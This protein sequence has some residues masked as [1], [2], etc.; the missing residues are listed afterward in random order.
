MRPFALASSLALWAAAALCA[1]EGAMSA[2]ELLP[3]DAAVVLRVPRVPQARAAL[4]G[5]DLGRFWSDPDVQLFVKPAWDAALAHYA[6]ARKQ[7]PAL[8]ALD[9]LAAALGGEL[10]VAVRLAENPAAPPAVSAVLGVA[11]A[12][13]AARALAPLL[14]GQPLEEGK[15]VRLSGQ[16]AGPAFVFKKGLLLFSSSAQDLDGMTARL[17]GAGDGALSTAPDWAK[18][19]KL[20]GEAGRLELYAEIAPLVRLALARADAEDRPQ[21]ETAIHKLGLDGVKTVLVQIG[22]RGAGLSLDAAILWDAPK[23]SL[24]GRLLAP[25]PIPAGALKSVPARATCVS[26]G[27]LDAPGLL[28]AIRGALD[29]EKGKDFEAALGRAKETLGFDIEKELLPLLDEV[30]VSYDVGT[31]EMFNLWSGITF[32]VGV[33]DAA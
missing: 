20:L 26:A 4:F 11:D 12:Q 27:R 21:L 16:D 32:T 15:L 7:N 22:G 17:G 18:A 24:V 25:A 31:R 13:A 14:K 28:A 5:S 29:E 9:D 2:P 1:A 33:K 3:G 10:A 30:W 19:H 6:A 23:D 8:P